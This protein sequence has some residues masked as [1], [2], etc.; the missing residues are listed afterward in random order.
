VFDGRRVSGHGPEY[1]YLQT[2][3]IFDENHVTLD[4]VYQGH[5]AHISPSDLTHGSHVYL[6]MRTEP[7]GRDQA[8]MAAM[9]TRQ[10]AVVVEAGSANPYVADVRY[11]L[12][13]FNHL[14]VELIRRAVRDAEPSSMTFR[15]PELRYGDRGY[16]SIT[17][18][19]RDGW[20]ATER[21]NTNSHRATS[22]PDG[23]YTLTFNGDD[24]ALNPLDVTAGWNGLFRC[25]LPTSV[26]GILEFGRDLTTNHPVTPLDG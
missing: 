6:F 24:S 15:P 4:V 12:D 1:E 11:D 10:D 7:P 25:Y 9:R 21:F 16:W 23:T 8:G 14:R 3:Q 20:V 17:L 18:Y 22:N 26:D 2:V 5:T 19:D 13:S